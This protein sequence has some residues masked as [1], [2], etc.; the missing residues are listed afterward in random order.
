LRLDPELAKRLPW[1]DADADP[2]GSATRIVAI[3]DSFT[4]GVWLP[5][6]QAY[7]ALLQDDLERSGLRVEVFNLGW[8]GSNTLDQVEIVRDALSRYRPGLVLLGF[9]VNDVE[10]SRAEQRDEH[11]APRE[12]R[13]VGAR[14]WA[15]RNEW[16]L[17]RYLR[18]RLLLVLH[19]LG[20]EAPQSLRYA[21]KIDAEYAE[22]GDRFRLCQ[23]ALL[24]IRELCAASGTPILVVVIPAMESFENYPFPNYHR[25][26]ISFCEEAGIAVH[27]LLPEFCGRK[28]LELRVSLLD[29][30]PNE[31]AYRVMATSI[32]RR[33]REE[34]WLRE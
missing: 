10:K 8:P 1:P 21:G 31:E 25:A 22:N 17:F 14:L 16:Y 29:N 20:F 33:L 11:R 27:D 13:G 32:G 23:E 7:P 4:R 12:K 34:T 6:E 30:H 18:P 19:E 9:F 15:L 2:F 26:V 24:G 3:G 5:A 28:P